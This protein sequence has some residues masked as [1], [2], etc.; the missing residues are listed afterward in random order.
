MLAFQRGTDAGY[1]VYTLD[2]RVGVGRALSISAAGSLA[3]PRYSPDGSKL[4]FVGQSSERRQD[5]FVAGAD[6]R[7][8]KSVVASPNASIQGP[9]WSPDSQTIAF[10]WNKDGNWEIYAVGADGTGLRRLTYHPAFDSTP[11]FSPDGRSIV[12]TSDRVGDQVGEDSHLYAMNV[13]GSGVRPITHGQ[14]ESSAD[15]APDGKRIAY[16][17]F[18]RGN[19]DI[20]V[21]DADGTR[22]RRIT[23]RPL[24]DYSPRWSPDGRWIAFEGY[25]AS[26]PELFV[27]RPDGSGLRQV[28][29]AGVYSGEPAWRPSPTR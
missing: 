25:V 15:F 6:G 8:A 2:V 29:H 21:A 24:F 12:F 7:D 9:A 16:V 1:R 13:D 17:G 10:H 11:A 28:T 26:Y 22:A 4:V 14:D 19:A 3:S 20:W 23:T 5:L 27:I 18:T